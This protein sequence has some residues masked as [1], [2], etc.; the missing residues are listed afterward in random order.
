MPSRT[1][2]GVTTLLECSMDLRLLG[3]D[4]TSMEDA[5]G[6]IVR[7]LRS[8]FVNK[9]TGQSALPLVRFYITRRA[10][11]LDP[12][13]RDFALAAGADTR[14]DDDVVCLT[15]LATAGE[16][17]AWNDR[18]RSAGH[19]AIPLPSVEALHR[20]PMVS[21]LVDQLGIPADQVVAPDPGM[22]R[23]L[24]NRSYNVFHV[25]DA[26]DHPSV[27]A[28]ADFVIPYGIRSAIGFGG[29][30]PNSSMF[31]VVA[32]SEI[33]IPDVAVDAFAAA[34]LSTKLAVLRHSGGPVFEPIG[35]TTPRP[36]F[37][38]PPDGAE[39]ERTLLEV[40]ANTTDQ[41]LVVRASMVMSEA[42]RLETEL[43]RAEERADELSKSRQALALSEA[44]KTAIVEGALDCVIG[45]AADGRITDFNQAAERTFGY[46]RDE[47]V[48]ELLGELIVP[49]GMRERHRLGLAHLLAT[50]EGPILG[51]RIEVPALHRDGHEFP[52][53]LTVTRIADTDP[54][55]FTGYMRDLTAARRA[56]EDLAASH[57]RLA[58]IARTLQTSLLPPALPEIDGYELAAA[59]HA[60]GD[61]YEVGG[62]FYDVYELADDH[63]AATLGDVCGA[64]SEAAALTA[65]VRYSMRTAAMRDRRPSAVLDTL[66][67]A[68]HRHGPS[69]F[70][71]AV[72]LT[73]E[74]STGSVLIALGGHAAPYV[75]RAAGAVEAVGA[76]GQLLGPFPMWKGVDTPVSLEADDLV[77]LFS[78]GVTEARRGD[79]QF[80]EDRVVAVLSETRGRSAAEVVRTLESAV[81][82]F[83]GS[84][85]DDVA[86]LALRRLP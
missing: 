71:T 70:C 39:W 7:Y 20:L 57:E 79:E 17:D 56:A 8:H 85:D 28:Q 63:W 14:V 26:R 37:A 11:Q 86:I 29:V 81:I 49:P 61:G 45:M 84:I 31:A 65:L 32:F 73:L 15:L 40:R 42:G 10:E 58:H 82:E 30:L 68:V 36:E 35:S 75:R 80:G 2:F 22:V 33:P 44:R 12:A 16:Q 72:Y 24:S 23:E 53:E 38:T 19:K 78:D 69:R 13:L 4:A 77:L 6:S 55:M 74:P 18:R 27:P 60:M 43:V 47:A 5:A 66:N 76:H 50:G 62:D 34:A 1:T 21:Q 67:E 25:A 59:F 54:P 51:R 52:V 48:G 64:G 3:D 83:A 41:L 46:A 9:E